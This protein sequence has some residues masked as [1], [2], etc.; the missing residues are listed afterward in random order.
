MII[1]IKLTV[2]DYYDYVGTYPMYATTKRVKSSLPRQLS[3]FTSLRYKKIANY[4]YRV[5]VL[6]SMT[7]E[8]LENAKEHIAIFSHLYSNFSLKLIKSE[9]I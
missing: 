2:R 7:A 6:V 9:L 3:V 5:T 1:R 8:E 4:H